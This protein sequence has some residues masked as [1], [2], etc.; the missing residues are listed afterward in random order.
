MRTDVSGDPSFRELLDRV[1]EASLAAFAHQDVPFERLVEDLTP[2]RSLARHP[3]FQVMLEPCT[4]DQ[5]TEAF[6]P[7]AGLDTSALRLESSAA[8]VDLAFAVSRGGADSG[9]RGALTYAADLFD[10]ASAVL[11]VERLVHVLETVL[12]SPDVST[13]RVE[14]LAAGERRH[15]LEEWNDTA[16]AAPRASLPVLFEE[17]VAAVP[18]AVAVV[19]G[20]ESLSYA[21]LDARVN[22]VARLLV[23]RGVGVESRVVVALPRSVDALVGLLAVQ[24]AGGAYV[25]VD[26][27][28][29]AERI[30]QVVGD[31]SPVLMLSASDALDS[32]VVSAAGVP[33]VFLDDAGVVAELAGLSPVS[34]GVVPDLLSAAYVIYTSGSTGRPK[35]V[36]VPHRGVVGVL[37]ALDGVVGADRVLAVTTFAFDIAV[38]ELFAPLVSGGCVVIAPSDVVADAELLVRLAV[39][40]GV[41]VIQAT[42]SLWREVVAVSGGRLGTVRG[43]VGGEALPGE[44]A[45][46]MVGELASVVNVYGPT[47]TTVWST[48]SQVT[49]GSMS[50][51]GVPLAGEAVFVLDEW[52]RPVPVGVRGELYVA[53][54]GVV[55][56]YFGRAD[57]TAE[58][59]VACPWDAGRRMYR[60]GDVVRWRAEGVLEYVGRSDAQVKV[61]GFRIELAEVESGLLDVGGVGRAVAVVND[62]VLIGYV[63]SEPGVVLSAS[64]V[65]EGLRSRLPEY[66]VPSVVVVLDAVPL[67]PNGKVDRK[68]L[69]APEEVAGSGSR[70]ARSPREEILCGLFGE[71]LGRVAVGIDEG[72]FDL[73]GHSLLATRLVSRIRAV[74]GVEVSIRDLFENPTVAGLGRVSGF[75]WRGASRVD[76]GGASCPGSVVVRA[77]AVVV[78]APSGRPVGHLQHSAGPALVG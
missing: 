49:G 18:D 23:S 66:M 52:L 62:G 73:G 31:S 34:L 58:R 27:G 35:G 56:G 46:A 28:Y 39:E 6:T 63:V 45:S 17:R 47:E 51:I 15:V 54:A 53:G 40:S 24:K 30:A 5:D 71:V 32:S 1:R 26:P 75:G 59:F 10:E 76:G 9:L 42:P 33:V 64:G 11:L 72:F 4:A 13:D 37:A 21:E 22:R 14:V 60:T 25:P 38:V 7:L 70:V 74:L 69:P 55:R 48:S 50:S 8:K 65:R 19:C 16:G 77:A 67:T 2:E 20:G 12:T 43:L 57:L 41:S 68:A 61:R 3:L 36:V 29:P 78:P 44:V